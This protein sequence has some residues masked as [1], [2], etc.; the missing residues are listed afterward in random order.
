M[1]H[2]KKPYA[3]QGLGMFCFLTIPGG[4]HHGESLGQ[5]RGQV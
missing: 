1:P 3:A 4:K 5:N 2:N